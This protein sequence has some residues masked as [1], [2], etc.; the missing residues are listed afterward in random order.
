VKTDWS[1]GD[2]DQADE[3][4]GAELAPIEQPTPA[5][6]DGPA[7]PPVVWR[8]GVV[9]YQTVDGGFYLVATDETGA[10]MRKHVPGALLKMLTRGPAARMLGK[11]FGR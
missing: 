3:L 7:G 9:I 11:A 10:E 1:D 8:G 5:E 4:P 6:L 2:E